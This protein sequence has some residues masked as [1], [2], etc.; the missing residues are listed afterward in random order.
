M[1][2][3]LDRERERSQNYEKRWAFNWSL[4]TLMRSTFRML[5]GRLF[6]NFGGSGSR[7]HFTGVFF[8]NAGHV[9]DQ[10]LFNEVQ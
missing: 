1:F 7:P 10:I 5:S 4:K 2:N 8:V 3:A 9:S 6:H